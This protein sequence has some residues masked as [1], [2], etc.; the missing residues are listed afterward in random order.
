[1][2]SDSPLGRCLGTQGINIVLARLQQALVARGLITTRVLAAPQDLSSGTLALT[3]VPGRVA[4]I[5]FAD[6]QGD[7]TSL[8]SAIAIR[9]GEV[10]NLR[11]IEQGLENLKR[12]PT[13]EADIQIEPATQHDARP[14]DSDLVVKYRQKFP[15]RTTLSLDNGGS[16]ATG[17]NQ[18]GVTVA[19]DNP[20]G[21]NDLAYVS[22]NHDALNPGGRGTRGYTAHYSVPYGAWLFGATASANSYH[23]T[24]PGLDQDYV[25]F[26]ES[27]NIDLSASRMV[28]RDASRKTSASLHAFQRSNSSG[29]NDVE[30][31]VQSRRVGGWELG[32]NHREFIGDAT[33]DANLLYRRGTGA[34]SSLRAPEEAFGDGTSR[35]QIFTA[36]AALNAPFNLAGQRFRYSGLWRA[37]WNRTPLTPQDKFAIGGRYTVRGFDGEQNLLGERGWLLRNDIGWA[38]GGSGAEVYAGIDHGQVGGPSVAYQLGSRL[39]GGV[40]GVRGAWQGL[41]YDVFV[42]APISKPEGFRTAKVTAGFNLNFSF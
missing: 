5:R 15:L 40:V 25:F 27:S 36:D 39:T 3:L 9:P 10:L 17:K 33:L 19:W 42:G 32:L 22:L 12:L 30:I 2:L 35:M 6:E 41:S 28:Y 1:G 16:E 11:A 26:G 37:Q 21:L 8:R 4:A 14:G 31:P 34:F 38:V 29:V 24:V 13:A 20:L 23:Q 7:K 18:A